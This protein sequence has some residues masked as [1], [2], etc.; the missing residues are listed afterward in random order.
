MLSRDN[1]AGV[2]LELLGRIFHPLFRTSSS[3]SS[4]SAKAALEIDDDSLPTNPASYLTTY[5]SL[6]GLANQIAAGMW[7][8]LTQ[9]VD[10]LPILSLEQ[11]E[12]L[13]K[14]IAFGSNSSSFAAFKSFELMAWLLHEPRLIASVPVF[15]I[16]A[17]KPLVYN[18]QAPIFVSTGAVKLLKYL[19]SRLEV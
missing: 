12:T 5:D 11:W 3:S 2:L 4:S 9:N 14:I 15:C 19:H 17:V 6:Q 16:I 13:F 1:Y 18:K 8:I 7:K 10:L